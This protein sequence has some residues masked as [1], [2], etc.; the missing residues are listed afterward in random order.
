MAVSIASSNSALTGG[1]S[2]T[3]AYTTTAAHQIIV[4]I[5]HSENN[6]AV[7]PVAV[8]TVTDTNGLTWAKRTSQSFL[9]PSSPNTYD[10]TEIW[11]AHAPAAVSG[12]ITVTMA[13]A[14]DGGGVMALSMAG[15]LNTA[16]PWDTNG[17]LPAK[18]TNATASAVAPS[19]TISTSSTASFVFGIWGSPTSNAQQ[20]VAPFGST[21]MGA[22]NNNGGVNFSHMFVE[23]AAFATVQ[24]SRVVSLNFANDRWGFIVDAISGD[25]APVTTPTLSRAMIVG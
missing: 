10:T 6:S 3:V 1:S 16:A 25:V 12:T 21:S 14:I 18:V 9:S 20:E 7:A 19:A 15:V 24:S 22:V 8:S 13:S 4:L 11:W 23:G 17:S 2:G 5:I